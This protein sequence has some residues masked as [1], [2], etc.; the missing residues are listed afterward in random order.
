VEELEQSRRKEAKIVR[1]YLEALRRRERELES[2]YGSDSWKITAP[3]RAIGRLIE[4]MWSPRRASSGPATCENA[5][6]R[7]GQ[8]LFL[9]GAYTYRCDVKTGIQRVVRNVLRCAPAVAPRLGYE[10]VPVLFENGHLVQAEPF[11]VRTQKRH[12]ARNW[13]GSRSHQRA[14]DLPQPMGS[15][16]SPRYDAGIR[17]DQYETHE[18]NILILLDAS[19]HF[20]IWQAVRRFKQK[21]GRVAGVVY[22][23]IPVSHPQTFDSQLA[24][25]FKDWL[26]QYLAVTNLTVGISR[27]TARAVENYV[28][29]QERAGTLICRAPVSHFKLGSDL[30]LIDP[31]QE[32]RSSFRTIFR[33]GR[34]VFLA[35]GTIEPRKN[36]RLMLNAFERLWLDGNTS[37]LVLV[38]H[39]SWGTEDLL[40][41][42][43]RHPERGKRLFLIRD[44]SDGELDFAYRNASALL[45]ASEI[46]G[47]GLPIVEALQR[48]LPVL[49]SDIPVFREVA[50]R[51]ARFFSIRDSENLTE[52]LREF[53][54][55]QDV[56]DRAVR[57]PQPWLNWTESTEQ[58]LSRVLEG[59]AQADG[60]ASGRAKRD[61]L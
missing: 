58:L 57:S 60:S 11:E 41:R 31:R 34:H 12:C 27:A 49:C 32:P 48:G 18:G 38:G 15:G 16:G 50:D 21:G 40:A 17:L 61:T 1:E 33:T 25:R 42:I 23:L 52:T 55:K 9:E 36:H 24:G 6:I 45:F 43:D 44:A 54:A 22:D 3:L 14:Q 5:P 46:E 10:V 59:C 47:F 28:A 29:D 7:S 20:P 4:G 39:Q 13:L 35:V 8:R 19:W 51:K 37:A 30:D 26:N 2:L 53:C 56:R